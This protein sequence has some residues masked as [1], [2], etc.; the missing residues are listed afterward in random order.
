MSGTDDE[1]FIIFLEESREHLADIEEDLLAIEE[2]GTN[3]DHELV[4][5]VFRAIHTVK[6]GSGFFALDKI[7]ELS[8]IMENVLD[9][10][11]KEKLTP[12]SGTINALLEG[13]DLLK[14]MINDPN[15]MDQIDTHAIIDRLDKI[16]LGESTENPACGVSKPQEEVLIPIHTPEGNLIF[17]IPETEINLALKE[18]KGGNLVYLVEYDLLNDIERKKKNPWDV[19]KEAMTLTY[20]V[21]S[22]VDFNAVGGLSGDID[23]MTI[24]FYVLLTTVMDKDLLSYFMDLPKEKIHEVVLPS[25]ALPETKKEAEVQKETPPV[26][27]EGAPAPPK[28]EKTQPE[29]AKPAKDKR[30]VEPATSENKPKA[31][32]QRTP[33][34]TKSEG[35]VRVNLKILDRLMTLAGELV[36]TR[37]QLLQSGTEENLQAMHVA[38]QAVDHLTT[39]LQDAI[40]QTR[41]QSI[42]LVFNKFKR[43]V[44]DMSSKLGKQ[45]ELTLEGEDV[46]L[47][48]TIIEKIGDPL[49]HLVRNS[50]DHGIEMPEERVKA[51]K[52]AKGVL[53]LKAA[54]EAG[55]VIID[56]VDDGQGLNLD[57]LKRK[58]L[59]NGIV[60]SQE[61]EEMTDK[62]VQMLIFKPGFSTAKKVTDISGRGVGMDVVRT[63]INDL[64]GITDLESTWGKGTKMQI[65]LPLTLAILPSLM[66]DVEG[67]RF[68]IPQAN[69]LEL[70][71][72]PA[73]DVKSKIEKIGDSPVIR[74]RGELLPL[75]SMKDVLGITA[76]TWTDEDGVV[77]PDRRENI[78]DRRSIV[79]GKKPEGDSDYREKRV[80][81][82]RRVSPTSSVN[83][84]VVQAGDMK[85]GLIVDRLHDSSEIVVKPLGSHLKKCQIYAGA[86][87]LG[88]GSVALILD[89]FGIRQFMQLDATAIKEHSKKELIQSEK[90]S[91][92]DWHELLLVENGPGERF[93]VP[94]DLVLRIEKINTSEIMITGGQQTIKYRGGSLGLFSI[95]DTAQVARRKESGT[96][97]I[98]VFKVA[99]REVGILV[100]DVI[101]IVKT[102]NEIDGVTHKQ[103]GIF[104]S[105]VIDNHVT[106]FLD[107]YG[108]VQSQAPHWMKGPAFHSANDQSGDKKLLLVEDSKFFRTQITEF[109]VEA[110]FDVDHEVNGQ[111]GLE[112]MQTHGQNYDLIISDIEMPVMDGLE[113]CTALREM[114]EFDQVPIIA[115]TSVSG[116]QAKEAGYKAGMDAYL[117]KLDRE[118]ILHHINGFLEYGRSWDHARKD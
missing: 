110:G 16:R 83:I 8:H 68:A 18:E 107:L 93:A 41:M 64:G 21:E 81:Q 48:R 33:V 89:V 82:D 40:M 71:R 36:L 111:K 27:T 59:E 103:S 70:V 84:A 24:P 96:A 30:Q 52:P 58:A 29:K 113:M 116:E 73:K 2:C 37:N 45:I 74:L 60:T 39:E 3:I 10:I 77:W 94:L 79:D 86:T 63:N 38:S 51:G 44:R 49:T 19:I 62:E 105:S 17:E 91:L 118:E 108:I 23:N 4:N 57:Q 76:R 14:S 75:V 112:R 7:K 92:K 117:I 20:F 88:D 56:I 12:E 102:N 85:L 28:R 50:I 46:E 100:N 6:G 34:V 115:V 98:I 109:L 97:N 55:F 78:V 13:S 1:V 35:S 80:Q 67:S 61:L 87:I 5:R 104:G 25:A 90:D 43:I 106:L 66:V 72:I 26:Q 9:M 69:L 95:E 53:H 47:D 15:E 114:S 11:R 42:G 54:H 65:K 32:T 22:K 101:D 99:N 31:K